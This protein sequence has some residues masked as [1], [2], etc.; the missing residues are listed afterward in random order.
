MA[1]PSS[2]ELPGNEITAKPESLRV[3]MLKE[4]LVKLAKAQTEAGSDISLFTPLHNKKTFRQN[5]ALVITAGTEFLLNPI[6]SYQ[7]VVVLTDDGGEALGMSTSSVAMKRWSES[8][9]P[10]FAGGLHRIVQEVASTGG[11]LN[12]LKERIKVHPEYRQFEFGS[13]TP[14]M[15]DQTLGKALEGVVSG[16]ALEKS[17]NGIPLN[18]ADQIVVDKFD[19]GKNPLKPG[20]GLYNRVIDTS[21]KLRQL[22]Q[23]PEPKQPKSDLLQSVRSR[24]PGGKRS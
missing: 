6:G 16:Q 17:I 8:N 7:G 15:M 13:I 22:T 23:G 19:F 3:G 12:D 4:N 2:P 9:R 10:S 1:E 21:D 5:E 20:V 24:L 11:D 14:E 18:A